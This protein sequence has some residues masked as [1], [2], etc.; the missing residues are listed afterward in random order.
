M[1]VLIFPSGA[2]AARGAAR[3]LIKLLRD[4]PGAVLG[5]PTGRTMIPLYETL[6]REH[7]RGRVEFA[8]AT[9]FNLDEFVGLAPGHPGSYRAFMRRH[10]FDRVD[11]RPEATHF[12]EEHGVGGVSYDES[13]ARAGGLDFCLVGLGTNG[14]IGFN[15]P[16]PFLEPRTH[17]VRLLP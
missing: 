15:E 7:Q 14:H 13:I 1:H 9:T 3:F 16:G 4:E 12:P 11:L 5:L 6:V 17:R 8:Q 10:L 2:D